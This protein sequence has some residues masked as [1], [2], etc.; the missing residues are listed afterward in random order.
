MSYDARSQAHRSFPWACS[1]KA[2]VQEMNNTIP[3]TKERPALELSILHYIDQHAEATQRQLSEHV[4]VSLG[5]IN[6]LLKKFVRRGWLQ[7]TRLQA[8]SVKYF[9]T[10]SGLANK[11]ERTYRYVIRT[12]DEINRIRSRI[13]T[14]AN[15]IVNA[16]DTD[17]L[18]F[19]GKDDELKTIIQDLIITDSFSRS[20]HLFH[21]ITDL[22]KQ[23][24]YTPTTPIV[25]WNQEMED[26]LTKED[27]PWVNMM[28][29]MTL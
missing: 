22:K 29:M 13:V 8:N 4:G 12:Y 14:I 25:I 3:M 15:S 10:P 27:I 17:Q 11:V 6:L 19:I 9:L 1:R 23:K 26:L 2:H 16:T 20:A 24:T 5:T 28:G 21:E 18:F 7:I